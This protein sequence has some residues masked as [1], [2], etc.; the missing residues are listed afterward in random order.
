M[1]G[2]KFKSLTV[3]P[4]YIQK[5][6]AIKWKCRCDCGNEIYVYSYALPKRKTN[7]C[8]QCRPSGVRNSKLYHVYHGMLQ[9]CYNKQNPSY[10]KYGAKGISVCERW[11]MSYQE[12]DT[13]SRANGY[14]EG[15]TIDRIDSSKD[16]S[17]DNCRWVSI[18]ENSRRAN[19]GAHKNKT[20]L[21]N[22]HAVSQTGKIVRIE[23]ISS[24]CNSYGLNRSVVSAA[25]HGRVPQTQYGWTFF[26]NKTK[27]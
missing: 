7:Y 17:P 21:Q 14:Q 25:L 10:C 4:E 18:S 19:V 27:S 8:K 24:F 23:N 9:R 11:R 15:L 26:S 2:R 3:L 13:W 1:S 5:G 22:I 20:K 6:S 12:F 16:Y